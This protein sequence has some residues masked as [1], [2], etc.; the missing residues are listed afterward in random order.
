M[1][2][3]SPKE[4]HHSFKFFDVYEVVVAYIE[5]FKQAFIFFNF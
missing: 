4:F 1:S 3:W 5:F 2:L